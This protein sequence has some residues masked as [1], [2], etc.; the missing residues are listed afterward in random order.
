MED[1]NCPNC[2]TTQAKVSIGVCD[3]CGFEFTEKIINDFLSVQQKKEEEIRRKLAE[4]ERQ[5]QQQ[6]RK[7][8]KEKQ[9]KIKAEKKAAA[10]EKKRIIKE[11]E[12]RERLKKLVRKDTVRY[13]REI[14]F[15]K[16]FLKFEKIISK[17]AIFLVILSIVSTFAFADVLNVEYIEPQ[18]HIQT[19]IQNIY[20]DFV[21]P[22]E[23]EGQSATE[24]NEDNDDEPI[25]MSK[26]TIKLIEAL[27]DVF[28][29]QSSIE[30]KLSFIFP[31]SDDF[32]IEISK[33]IEELIE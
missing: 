14:K 17:V 6:Q 10:L 29:N 3:C 22:F 9:E 20:I 8:E 31:F 32:I 1:L 4:Q 25:M 11:R 18:E 19:K 30:D 12:E 33:R 28:K 15:S 13:N 7:E 21:V 5:R 16:I 26:S 27:T 2:G 24:K 23:Y